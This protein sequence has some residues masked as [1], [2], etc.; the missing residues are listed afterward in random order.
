MKMG[1]PVQ[2]CKEHWDIFMAL[3]YTRKERG[4]KVGTDQPV[5]AIWHINIILGGETLQDTS[6]SHLI[7]LLYF[8]RHPMTGYL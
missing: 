3:G 4:K 2:H 8:Y 6:V 1:M 7:P 5:L